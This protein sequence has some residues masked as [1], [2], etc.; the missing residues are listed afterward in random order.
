MSSTR[1]LAWKEWREQRPVVLAGVLI[2][3][4][5]PFIM[6]ACTALTG[7]RLD[8]ADMA[9]VLPAIFAAL[10]LPVFAAAAGGGTIASE[11]GD[12][13]M[14]FLLSRPVPRARIWSVKMTIGAASIL[15]ILAAS[16]LVTWVFG[17]VAHAGEGWSWIPE[18]VGRALEGQA[19]LAALSAITLLFAASVFFSTFLSRAMNAVFAGIVSSMAMMMFLFVIWSRLDIMPRLEPGL[20]VLELVLAAVA[21][22]FM[23]CCRFQSEFSFLGR[24][25]F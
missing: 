2:S 3:I 17:R 21:F 13:T 8:L 6:I 11:H 25:L 7:G 18:I 4:A 9:E 15:A 16:L 1:A 20:F 12:G 19:I 10:W 14:G 23:H 22:L 24:R 5:T